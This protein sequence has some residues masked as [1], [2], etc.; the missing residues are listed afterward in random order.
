MFWPKQYERSRPP[1][2][3]ADDESRL[4]G[5]EMSNGAAHNRRLAVILYILADER[6][7]MLAEK[8]VYCTWEIAWPKVRDAARWKS[9]RAVVAAYSAYHVL[10]VARTLTT[11]ALA[12][13]R[14]R[15]FAPCRVLVGL[16]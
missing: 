5:A 8:T 9:Q 11:V 4:K 1:L 6:R 10:R 3:S 16:I 12:R 7:C 15:P 2:Y 13:G 14:H